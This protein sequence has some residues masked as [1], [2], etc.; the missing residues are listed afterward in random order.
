MDGSASFDL[1]L[2]KYRPW[3]EGKGMENVVI[4]ISVFLNDLPN[5]FQWIWG[6][7]EKILLHLTPLKMQFVRI[8]VFA[9]PEKPFLTMGLKQ[10]NHKIFVN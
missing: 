2:L 5:C 6:C 9:Y 7:L 1:S 10:C 8:S 4:Q 3:Q